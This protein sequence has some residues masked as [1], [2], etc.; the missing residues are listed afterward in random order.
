MIN[1]IAAIKIVRE[2][3]SLG[4]KES[5]DLVE[6]IAPFLQFDK[7]DVDVEYTTIRERIR[8]I[9]AYGVTITPSNVEELNRLVQRRTELRDWYTRNN[10]PKP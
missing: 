7:Y 2:E 3:T 5:K 4:L 9:T 6:R 1:K 8:A 10:Y